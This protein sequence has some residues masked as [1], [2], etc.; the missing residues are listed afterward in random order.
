MDNEL[1]GNKIDSRTSL[2]PIPSTESESIDHGNEAIEGIKS[3]AELAAAKAAIGESD[4]ITIT[5]KTPVISEATKTAL[6]E[7]AKGQP[8]DAALPEGLK[9][10]TLSA[11]LNNSSDA[12][13]F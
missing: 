5:P 11:M 12:P 4:K 1:S 10:E 6:Q 9:Q 2:P 8:A 3:D 7:A 13:N